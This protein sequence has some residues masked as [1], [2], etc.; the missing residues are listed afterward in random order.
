VVGEFTVRFDVRADVNW[1]YPVLMLLVWVF[2]SHVPVVMIVRSRRVREWFNVVLGVLILA[3][4]LGLGGFIIALQ[5]QGRWQAVRW[6][7]SGDYEIVEGP[8]TDYQHSTTSPNWSATYKVGGVPFRSTNNP[9]N[10]CETPRT[11]P[12][13]G[14]IRSDAYLRIAHHNGRVL[15]VEVRD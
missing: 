2:F 12:H 5:V 4:W 3:V 15:R 6:A 13:G 8:V 9:F 1:L 14:P 11:A 7:E 10:G